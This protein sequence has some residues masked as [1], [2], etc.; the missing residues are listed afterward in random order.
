MRGLDGVD[1]VRMWCG[2]E[3]VL[4][5]FGRCEN[6]RCRSLHFPQSEVHGIYNDIKTSK[7]SFGMDVIVTFKMSHLGILSCFSSIW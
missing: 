4:E 5:V 6:L 2:V 3:E 7:G 1:I